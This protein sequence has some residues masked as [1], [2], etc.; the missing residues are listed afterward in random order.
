MAPIEG[1]LRQGLPAVVEEGHQLHS[2][3]H[4]RWTKGFSPGSLRHRGG[5]TVP[6]FTPTLSTRVQEKR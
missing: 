6:S 2:C 3:L 1:A 5:S 4:L